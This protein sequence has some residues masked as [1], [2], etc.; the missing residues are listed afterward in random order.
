M[1]MNYTAEPKR[2]QTRKAT[3]DGTLRALALAGSPRVSDNCHDAGVTILTGPGFLVVATFLPSSHDSKEIAHMKRTSTVVFGFFFAFLAVVASAQMTPPTPAPELKKLDYFT[4]TWTS[5][6]T[7]V[8]GP[9]GS[10]GKFTD[11]VKAEWMKG[12][13]F[14]LSHSDFSMPEEMGG[15]GESLAV[16]WYDA[17]KKTYQEER[18]DSN[19]RHVAAT[20]TLNGDTLTWTGEHNYGGMT[21]QSRLAIKMVSPT[22]FTSKYEVSA[23]SGATWLPFWEGKATKK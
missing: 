11:S 10:G 12:D 19:G 16:L 8:P 4:G 21:I 23:D 15:A 9:W 13:F 20:G 3:S 7:I 17:D 6:A 22:S 14:L 5:E 2:A 18:F 1:E